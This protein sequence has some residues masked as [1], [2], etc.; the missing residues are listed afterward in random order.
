VHGVERLPVIEAEWMG[1]GGGLLSAFTV[2]GARSFRATLSLAGGPTDQRGAL[3]VSGP[4]VRDTAHYSFG[5]A[6]AR[7]APNLGAPWGSDSVANG[8]VATAN[9]SFQVDL[10]PYQADWKPTTTIISAFGRFDWLVAPNHRLMVRAD[11]ATA[12][13]DDPVLGSTAPAALGATFTSRDISLATMLSSTFGRRVG[14]EFKFSFDAGNRDYTGTGLVGTAFTEG[15]FAAGTTDILPGLFKRQT[16]RLSETA[17]Y[18]LPF[19]ILKAGL[20]FGFNSFDQ[21]F[22]EGRAGFFIFGDSLG[23][24]GRTGSFRQ[25]VGSVPATSFTTSTIF[26]FVQ[27]LLRPT[28]SLAIQAGLRYEQEKLPVE[29][30]RLNTDWQKATGIDNRVVPG[31]RVLASPRVSFTWTPD[32]QRRWQVVGEAGRSVEQTDP[33]QFA[34]ALTHDIGVPIRRAFGTLGAWP[35]VPDSTVAPVVGKSVTLLGP[36]YAPPQTVRAR[37]GITGNVGGTILRL[38]SAYRHTDFLPLRRDLNLATS[39]RGRDQDGRVIYGTLTKA[40]T[41]VGPVPGTNRRFSAFDDVS[42]IDPAA[43]SDYY[44]L[45]AG[46]E[47]MVSRGISLMVSYTF[48]RSTDNWFGARDG[49]REAQFVPFADSTGVSAYAQGRS[50]FDVPHRLVLGTE[51]RFGGS[52]GKLIALYRRQSGYPFTPGFRD[53]VDINGDGSGRN[54]PAFVSDTLPGADVVVRGSSCLRSQT[55]RFAERNSCREPA[56]GMLDLRLVFQLGRLAGGGTELTFDVLNLIASG[57]DVTDHALYLVDR[58]VPLATTPAGVTRVPLVA[59]PN[60]GEPL[61]KRN[62]GVG[63]RLGVRVGL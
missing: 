49:S 28:G 18:R 39:S 13:A 25:S 59:N 3:V 42:S 33:A 4:A 32:A 38:Q 24:A 31:R 57:Q 61:M 41:L 51:I 46:I 60:F 54:D 12:S 44:G 6:A 43:A 21:T 58:T 35:A 56:M 16:I 23:F 7:L 5:I 34:E 53:G 29:N 10:S 9:D 15:G 45:S 48:S 50:D 47:R 40:G 26:G 36:Q 27:A 19:G 52:R 63:F 2:P 8:T 1:A 11:A 30:L 14:S 20:G 62:P 55:S 22:T 17:H 37:F